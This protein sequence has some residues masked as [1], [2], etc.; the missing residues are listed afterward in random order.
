M[1]ACTACGDTTSE[2][3]DALAQDVDAS[4]GTE[5]GGPGRI[6]GGASS[7]TTDSGGMSDTETSTDAR[8][9][10]VQSK[11]TMAVDSGIIAFCNKAKC[12]DVRKRY[13]D[14]F[15]SAVA[16]S[17]T[18][19]NPCTFKATTDLACGVFA[20]V[21]QDSSLSPYAKEWESANCNSCDFGCRTQIAQ[22][23]LNPGY[24]EK[25][26]RTAMQL[27]AVP[28][29]IDPLPIF[30]PIGILNDGICKARSFVILPL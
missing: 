12:D 23:I 29:P 2:V 15:A 7:E 19:R 9:D 8:P 17:S 1:S 30:P 6:R 27:V 20:W 11:D 14:A 26:L 13:K 18:S 25:N 5:L 4:G 24:C 21:N 22:P 10:A 16:C 3:A 28:L